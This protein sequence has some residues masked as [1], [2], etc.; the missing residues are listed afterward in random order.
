MGCGCKP[1]KQREEKKAE[2]EAEKLKPF[3]RFA[4]DTDLEQHLKKKQRWGD[5]MAK[6]VQSEQKKNNYG[7]IQKPVYRGPPGPANRY[8]I[9]PGHRWDGIDRSNGFEKKLF[10]HRAQQSAT[11]E[12]AYKWSVEDM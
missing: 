10:E 4:D 9:V 6:L 12:K 5:P 7:Q 3:A 8:N 2:Y 11:K 1:K